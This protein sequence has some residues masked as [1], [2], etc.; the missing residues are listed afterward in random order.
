GLAGVVGDRERIGAGF[1]CDHGIPSVASVARPG[2]EKRP[3][4]FSA[5]RTGATSPC[6][7]IGSS[8]AIYLPD[9]HE[10]PTA[11]GNCQTE[12][13]WPAP[14]TAVTSYQTSRHTNSRPA[15]T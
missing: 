9:P 6:P 3:P 11:H 5:S 4:G 7:A 12:V 15:S 14:A 2:D 1:E 8:C 10:S 13:K